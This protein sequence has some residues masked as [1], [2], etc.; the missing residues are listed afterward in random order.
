MSKYHIALTD[1]EKALLQAITIRFESFEH[2]PRDIYLRN[3]KPVL[4]IVKSLIK[5]DAIPEVRLRFWSDPEYRINRRN[6]SSPKE[7]FERNRCTGDDIFTDLRFLPH[8]RYFLF[9]ADLPDEVISKFDN[10]VGNPEWVTS[11]DIEPM[12]KC[13]RSLIREFDLDRRRAPEEFYKLCL[14]IGLELWE[15]RMV[16]ESAKRVP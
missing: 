11:G 15:A 13:A 8:L 6:K 14:D 10:Q 9:G 3:E 1:N 12:G 5:R 7:V 2:D 4:E 16:M